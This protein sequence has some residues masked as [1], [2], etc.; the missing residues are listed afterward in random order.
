MAI[1]SRCR[2]SAAQI[3]AMARQ[4]AQESGFEDWQTFAKGERG[5][6]SPALERLLAENTEEKKH[7]PVPKKGAQIQPSHSW[8]VDYTLRGKRF[9]ETFAT[10]KDAEARQKKI[11]ADI[12]AMKHVP[13]TESLTIKEAS[14]NWIAARKVDTKGNK[15]PAEAS[16]IRMYEGHARKILAH[17]GDDLKLCDLTKGAAEQFKTVLLEGHSRPTA[18]KVLV[19][20]KGLLNYAVGVGQLPVNVVAGMGV[21][22]KKGAKGKAKVP[23]IAD[24]KAILAKLDKLAAQPNKQRAKAWRRYRVLI[25]TA[26][27]TGMRASEIR[28][29]PWKH[30]HLDDSRIDVH[31]RADENGKIAEITKSTA[32]RRSIYIPPATVQMLK[33]WKLESGGKGLVFGTEAEKP[34]S[35]ANI[36]SRAWKPLLLACGVCDPVADKNG[37]VVRAKDGKPVMKPRYNFHLLRHYH[38]SRLI[39]GGE[40]VKEVQ[41]E[42]GHSSAMVTLDIYGDLFSDEEANERR[43]GR[44]ARMAL[45]E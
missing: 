3:E 14:E 34:M 8:L 21:G 26:I 10:F 4:I 43:K 11:D 24:I 6:A 38:A 39:A 29:L 2:F 1:R 13:K 22:N 33:E 18:H 20:L 19:S 32:G 12:L 16:T 45:E 31:Q 28:G 42:L 30:V 27:R 9:A 17:F 44:A 23:A 25:V 7:G 15:G 5:I 40:N 36:Y 35:L 41:A 37:D